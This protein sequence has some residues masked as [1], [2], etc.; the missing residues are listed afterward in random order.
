MPSTDEV[1]SDS[2]TIEWVKKEVGDSSAFWEAIS[3]FL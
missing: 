1:R 3:L 2:V